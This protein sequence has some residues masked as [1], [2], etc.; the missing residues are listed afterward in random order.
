MIADMRLTK[1]GWGRNRTADTWIFSPLLCQLSY[2]A[3]MAP[4]VGRRGIFT[5]QQCNC[6]A[7]AALAILARQGDNH[8]CAPQAPPL[9]CSHAPVGRF[10]RLNQKAIELGTAPWLQPLKSLAALSPIH[11]A[12]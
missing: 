4:I 3:V 1:T 11:C 9:R 8:L 10:H 2:P 7:S 12:P 5:M 6:R